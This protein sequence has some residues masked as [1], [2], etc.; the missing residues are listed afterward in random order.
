MLTVI[1][2]LSTKNSDAGVVLAALENL[3]KYSRKEVGCLR[4][5]LS[6]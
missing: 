1:A 3:Q 6:V 2:T 4:Y 5:D